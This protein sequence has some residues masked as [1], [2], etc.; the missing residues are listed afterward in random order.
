MIEPANLSRWRV[1][2]KTLANGCE[3]HPNGGVFP[4]RVLKLLKKKR[5]DKGVVAILP[6][7]RPAHPLK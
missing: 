3:S 4:E 5:I 7:D 1:S 2:P 6:T